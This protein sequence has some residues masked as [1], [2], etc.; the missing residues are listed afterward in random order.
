MDQLT[1]LSELVIEENQERKNC[2]EKYI[3]QLEKI[4][5]NINKKIEDEKTARLYFES[6]LANKFDEKINNIKNMMIKERCEKDEIIK[7]NLETCMDKFNK[8]SKLLKDENL[9]SENKLPNEKIFEEEI[10]KDVSSSIQAFKETIN[11]EKEINEENKSNLSNAV[12]NMKSKY[13]EEIKQL[14]EGR[15]SNESRLID[16]IQTI[17]EKFEKM[18]IKNKIQKTLI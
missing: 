11:M 15:K 12:I 6:N 14:K 5:S 17:Y 18:K 2:K 3:L 13:M 1:N 7:H 4:K 8:V 16:L 9:N 10:I